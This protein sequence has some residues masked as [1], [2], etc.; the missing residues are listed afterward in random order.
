MKKIYSVMIMGFVIFVLCSCGIANRASDSGTD[1][2]T[3]EKGQ[4]ERNSFEASLRFSNSMFSY[5]NRIDA[6]RQRTIDN[7]IIGTCEALK[8]SYDIIW[9]ND[10]WIYVMVENEKYESVLYRI[11]LIR[12]N[13][14]ESLDYEK[15]EK[16]LAW[17]ES[18]NI[19]RDQFYL[20]DEKMFFLNEEEAQIV[21][22]S[23]QDMKKTVLMEDEIFHGS[24][25]FLAKENWAGSSYEKPIQQKS[26]VF[27]GVSR[28]KE[29]LY[30]LD[31]ESG[32]VKQ[33]CEEEG[34]KGSSFLG[35]DMFTELTD[36]SIFFSLNGRKMMTYD[37]E[38][39]DV[40]CV[41]SE[42]SLKETVKKSMALKTTPEVHIDQ[43]RYVN[44]ELYCLVYVGW[45]QEEKNKEVSY[46][47]SE[48]FHLIDFN[49]WEM[50][51]YYES[52]IDSLPNSITWW[53]E[54]KV[55]NIPNIALT[56]EEIVISQPKKSD[57]GAWRYFKYNWNTHKGEKLSEDKAIN[58]YWY[59]FTE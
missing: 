13:N 24:M 23:L 44:G 8:G 37:C 12:E 4:V 38:K 5:E 17:S 10:E 26:Y 34:D 49:H 48:L 33:I 35:Y 57:Y 42:S 16:L 20:T 21:Q 14:K 39:D 9:V 30:R 19:Y 11:P 59:L 52:Y 47:R 22:Y 15:K 50:D 2:E 25:L 27:I 55:E 46:R 45:K 7:K 54:E 43:V 18:A 58:Q 56:K 32:E 28:E 3:T 36:S 51:K 6:Y 31:M 1:E 53:E 41:V 29:W 40:S